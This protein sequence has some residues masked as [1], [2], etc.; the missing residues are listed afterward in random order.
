MEIQPTIDYMNQFFGSRI[1]EYELMMRDAGGSRHP[2][3]YVGH[4]EVIQD[5]RN[6]VHGITN[7]FAD[8]SVPSGYA[9]P[10][11]LLERLVAFRDLM[12]KQANDLLA[13]NEKL[14]SSWYDDLGYAYKMSF[15]VSEAITYALTLSVQVPATPALD[16]L[17][18]LLG[19]LP[20]VAR[21]L[22]RRRKDKGEVRPTLVIR[23]EY[24][25]QDLLRSVL[26]LEFDDIRDEEWMPSYADS[27][28]RADFLLYEEGIVVEVKK[29]RSNLQQG[30]IADQLAID[31][32]NYK[33]RPNTIHV[34]C[35]VWD[36]D[37]I[38]SNPVALKMDIEKANKGFV[39]IVVMR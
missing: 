21:Q 5:I 35:A 7:L 28:K 38:L 22:I 25:V 1:R 8:M 16:R 36:T 9:T 15:D 20:T 33:T 11:L 29:T 10:K 23:D 32:A 4:T 26:H 27:S 17:L 12:A 2:E 31:I 19:R 24:D 37:H 13:L 3:P 34:V 14:E 6:V 30:M 18:R 39:S